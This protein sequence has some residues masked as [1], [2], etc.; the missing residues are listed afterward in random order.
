MVMVGANNWGGLPDRPNHFVD[1]KEECKTV[2]TK[3]TN[4]PCQVVTITGP[5]G[6]GKSAIAVQVGHDLCCRHGV[7]V[8]YITLRN[9]TSLVCMANSLLRALRIVASERES[10]VKQAMHVFCNRT[11]ET[12]IILDNAEDMLVESLGQ[13]FINFVEDIAKMARFVRILVTSR[14]SM[15]FL[16]VESYQLSLNALQPEDAQEVLKLSGAKVVHEDAETLANLCGGVPL[17][18]HTTASVLAKKSIKPK[19][20]ISEFEKSPASGFNAFNIITLSRDHQI[21]H[22]LNICFERLSTDLKQGLI[23]LSVFPTAFEAE[24]AQAVLKKHSEFTLEVHLQELVDNSLL[25]YDQIAKQYSIHAVIQAFC[26]E[27]AKKEEFNSLFA[28]AKKDFNCHYLELLKVFHNNFLST[29]V[30]STVQR[31]LV[32]RRHIRQAMLDSVQDP[33]L[34]LTC[35]DTA[36]RVSPFLAKVFR[37]EK[38]LQIYEMYSKLCKDMNDDKRYSDCLTAEAYCILSHCACHLPCPSAVAKFKEAHAIQ[39]RL[40]DKSSSM[41]AHC[42]IKLGRCISH[43]GEFEK[44]IQLIKKGMSIREMKKN[45]IQLA[46]AYK[47]MAGRR[48]S[49]FVILLLD[50]ITM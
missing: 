5:P 2:I 28:M 36:N 14:L 49:S 4:S 24:D 11:C 6:F 41:R 44:G 17:V 21:F 50:S 37:K 10:P 18:L 3:L 48:I 33:D 29:K 43:Y 19:A 7:S 40:G 20:L 38:C 34:Q 35:I 31:F 39:Q 15:T 47:D 8:F 30:T 45:E 27:E 42:L 23:A 16:D 25:Q 13:D 26:N 22:C 32:K 1:R 9:C 12:V 46:V